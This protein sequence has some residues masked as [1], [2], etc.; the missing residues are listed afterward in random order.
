MK[1]NNVTIV[2][3]T[4]AHVP[5]VAELERLCFSTPWN[6][7]IL[8]HELVNPLSLWYVAEVEGQ[9]AG[10]VGSQTVIDEADMMNI[11]VFPQFRRM[12]IAKMLLDKLEDTLAGN[13]VLWLALEVRA[14][15]EA[16]IT[17]YQSRGYEQVG[18]RPRYYF[19]PTEDAL[20]L[21]KGLMPH[22]NSGN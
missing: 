21:K 12:G 9:V 18:R 14:S 16:A 4:A 2:P 5:A 6:E 20:I 15:N 3:M 1:Q 17:L 19:K 7:D 11:A 13:G 22:E 8:N 10:Y